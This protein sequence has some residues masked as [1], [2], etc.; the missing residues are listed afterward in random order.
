MLVS[1]TIIRYPGKYVPFAFLAMAAFRLPLSL[2]KKLSFYKLMGCGKN[3]TFDKTPDVNQ[4]AILAVHKEDPCF[5]ENKTLYGTFIDSWWKR[6][7][8]ETFT[9]F[10]DPIEG[11]GKWD[12]KKVFGELSGKSDYEGQI[13]TLTRA[14][15]RFNKL[16]YFW[17]HVA[18]VAARMNSAAGFIMSV[19][20]GEVPWVKQATF[21]VWQN[22]EAM[23]AFA[24]Q[25]KEHTEVI[26]MTRE[27]KWYSE[28]MFVR[29]RILGT[30]GTIKGVK[31]LGGIS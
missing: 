30:T 25:M 23:K 19:G 17:K 26:K 9:I 31:P 16:T 6:F 12:G 10:L 13:A 27:Q 14:T 18:P 15:I 1:L 28:D 5:H 8:C 7:K 22:K 11:H 21:S 4:W 29:F 20:I 3:G 2:N 24:Y